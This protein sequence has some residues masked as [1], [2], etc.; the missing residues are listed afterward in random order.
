MINAR[1]A[2]RLSS[3]TY[4]KEYADFFSRCMSV[5]EEKIYESTKKGEFKTKIHWDS[6][7]PKESDFRFRF[8]LEE[9]LENLGYDA[10]YLANDYLT[11]DWERGK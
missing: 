6:L 5:I 2:Y 3:E 8:R 1:N 4:E 11:I 9:D 7:L 10:H